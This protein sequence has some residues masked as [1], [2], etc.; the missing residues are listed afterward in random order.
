MI[1]FT[2]DLHLGHSNIIRHCE[3]PFAN[4]EEMDETL[5]A[6]WNKRVRS[7]DSVYILGDLIFRASASPDGYLAGL[8]GKKHLIL[9]N[10]D[11]DWV[12]KA[13][14]ERYFESVAPFAEI[15]AEQQR[16]SLCHYPMMSWNHM[17]K[18]AYM[19][20]GHIHNNRNADYFPLMRKMPNLLNAGV[21]INGFRPVGLCELI[22]NNENFKSEYTD[23]EVSADTATGFA[24][25]AERVN[26]PSVLLRDPEPVRDYREFYCDTRLNPNKI[27]L[28]AEQQLFTE[29]A[30][31]GKNILV[32]ACI[33]SGKTTAIQHLCNELPSNTKILYLT[34]NKLLKLDAKTKIKNM[35]ATVSNYHGFAFT[36]LKTAGVTTGISDLIQ[37][38]NTEKPALD[39]YDVLIIDEYQDIEQELSEM[40]LY[41]KSTNSTMQIVAVGDMEQKIYDKTT[42]SV[43]EFMEQFLGR[44]IKLE[45]TRCFRLSA[46]LA[47]TL[48]RIWCKNIIGVNNNCIV[49]EMDV[50]D[51]VKFLSEQNPRDILCLG[52]RTGELSET[53]NI[54]E[55]EY[56]RKFNK[57]TV[58]ASISDK[59]GTGATQPK[60][61]SAIFTTFDSSKGLERKICVV[62]DYVE[63][64]WQVRIS[65]PQQSYKILRN[66]FCVA[67]S[68]GKERIIFVNSGEAM[69]SERTLSTEV[70]AG[71]TFQNVDISE[72]FDFK[73][74]ED[75]EECYSLLRTRLL[76][77]PEDISEIRVVGKDELID[78]S[79]CIG[80]YQEAVFF[81]GYDID[82][83]IKLW[84]D[85][86][87]DKKFLHAAE[88][89]NL[90]IDKKIL[91]LTSL[92]TKQNRYRNQVATPFVS[93]SERQ[94]IAERLG[95]LFTVDEM[96]QSPC[97]IDFSNTKEGKCLFSAQGF[98]D[99]VKDDVVYELKFVSELTHE[100]FLQCACYVV[101]LGLETGILWNT[102]TNVRY[103]I[104]IPDRARFLDAV[105]KTIT[106]GFL[107]NYYAPKE[108]SVWRN[109]QSLTQKRTG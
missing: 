21:D 71:N 101:A 66:I 85:L 16:V 52:A 56:P 2:A 108:E 20:H 57:S 89:S 37:I 10:H 69:L 7:G 102:R 73:Y 98:T 4:V 97:A 1:Y 13:D 91:I 86:N 68:R 36:A 65:K 50:D 84:L 58:F 40:L 103:E 35:N 79:P 51:V 61:T 17:A 92:E 78:L 107:K 31:E 48:G 64:Y 14:L 12:K 83:S 62:F 30:K 99:V 42:L 54:L 90:P 106:K 82:K 34:Y 43:P 8:N 94:Q 23:R 59:D 77:A 19:I 93:N 95:S 25:I 70:A 72:M 63:S 15:S 24:G 9:G 46:G 88:D 5:I 28:S 44:H 6:N 80:I 26:R 47:G 18:G 38:F 100:H 45:F 49:E 109:L 76:T 81:K 74:K 55:R 75:V 32:D 29:K 87:K 67:A 11:K 41:I 104:Q 105:A 27:T 33:G 60:P 22:A 3:R 53:L 96:V 39:H